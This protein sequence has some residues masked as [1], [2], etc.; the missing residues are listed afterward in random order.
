MKNKAVFITGGDGYLG[1]R[2][3]RRYL[4]NT[5]HPVWLWVRANDR[6]DLL[7][8]Q[9]R[10]AAQLPTYASRITC[11]GGDLTST[12]PFAEVEP[13]TITQIVHCAAIT[14]FNVDEE[15]ARRTNIEGTRHV[16]E[17]A[18][19][20]PNLEGV[21]LVSTAYASGLRPGVIEEERLSGDAGFANHYERSKWAAEDMLFEQYAHLPW[22]IFR[23][24]TVIADDAAGRLTQFNAVHN[25][26]K[27]FYYGLLSFVPG[28]PNTPLYFVTGDMMSQS[29]FELMED[30]EREAVY[31]LA[32]RQDECLRLAEMIDLAYEAFSEDAEFRARR[33]LKPLFSDAESFDLLVEGVRSFGGGVVKQALSSVAPFARQLFVV[34]DVRNTR[35][36]TDYDGFRAP[37]IHRVMRN[38]C[39]QLV[40]TRWGKAEAQRLAS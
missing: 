1:L 38:T 15:S 3:A 35:T 28:L 24:A 34:K 7:A 17:L 8:K 30:G 2:T 5:G 31:H 26:L 20:C 21:S 9:E 40:A 4:E 19:R 37:D 23:M 6:N 18:T 12:S 25:T 16:L 36:T 29:L 13:R 10:I 32:H 14:R 27:L 11:F 22:Q 39:A 33:V